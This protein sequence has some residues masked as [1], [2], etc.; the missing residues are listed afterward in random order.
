MHADRD[1]PALNV[2][3]RGFLKDVAAVAAVGPVVESA[4]QSRG[5]SQ[6]PLFAYVGTYSAGGSAAGGRGIYLFS[7]DRATGVLTEHEVFVN[8]SNPSWLA[9]SPSRTHLYAANEVSNFQGGTTGSVSAYRIN[10][11]TGVLT[12]L[13]AVSSEGAG[14]AHVSVHPSGRFAFVANYGGGTVAVLPIRE[15]GDLGQAID[16]KRHQGTVGPARATNAPTGS[17]AISGHNGPHAHMIQSD[18]AGRFVF[19]AD[20]GLDVIFSWT[21]DSSSGAL[22]PTDPPSVALPPGDG[23]RHFVFHPNG[24]WCYSL[25]E[26]SSTVVTFDYL[27]ATG[28]LTAKQTVSSL[29]KGFVGTNFTSEIALSPDSRFLYAANRL[30]DSIAW[31]AIGSQGTL[32]FLGEAWTRGDYP[33]S[34]TIEPGGNFLYC[35]NQRS[36]AVTTF[37]IDKKTGALTFTGRY[38]P[39][40]APAMVVFL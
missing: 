24:R 20:L 23:P 39:V 27:A 32:T 38:T 21:F 16:V 13:N 6:P 2:T 29:P 40:G 3:R 12:P 31:F 5:Q 34:F 37:R 4:I 26:E 25:Q 36:D 10:R 15:G 28:R 30:H 17:F 35:C 9:M 8:A 22:T 33:R 19:A 1:R 11:T 14:P 18:P 7:V